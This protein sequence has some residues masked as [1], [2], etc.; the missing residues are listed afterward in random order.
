MNSVVVTKH[1]LKRIKSRIGLNKKTIEK[2]A[3]EAYVSGIPQSQTH[4]NLNRYLYKI[5]TLKR[6]VKMYNHFIFF[7]DKNVL[8]TVYPLPG[9]IHRHANKC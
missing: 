5:N 9:G 6:N 4:G 7:F 8:I 1:A 3:T 2:Y